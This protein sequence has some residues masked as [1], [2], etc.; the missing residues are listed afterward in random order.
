[1]KRYHHPQTTSWWTVLIIMATVAA[2]LMITSQLAVPAEVTGAF[3]PND[4]RLVSDIRI[5]CVG[6]Q[7]VYQHFYATVARQGVSGEYDLLT[8]GLLTGDQHE[9]PRLFVWWPP[10]AAEGTDATDVY[11]AFPGQLVERL[12]P[13]VAAQRYP[14]ACS[15]LGLPSG[16]ESR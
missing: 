4:A 2:A 7:Q 10:T 14:N 16:L 9:A 6:G 12:D 1:M 5:T 15:M 8:V 3:V 11:V 13:T